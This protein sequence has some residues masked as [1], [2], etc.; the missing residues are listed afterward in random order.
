RQLVQSAI[1]GFDDYPYPLTSATSLQSILDWAN[2]L[3]QGQ[4]KATPLAQAN[5]NYPLTPG[6]K[7]DI[8]NIAYMVQVGDTLAAIA[9]RYADPQ[10]PDNSSAAALILGNQAQ[11]NLIVPGV[12]IA[13]TLDGA[14]RQYTT[15]AGDSFTSIAQAFAITVERLAGETTLYTQA[16]LLSA[17]V[18]L[19]VPNVIVTTAAGDSI[20]SITEALRVPLD[21][22]L[23]AANLVQEGLF[24]VDASLR[25]AIPALVVLPEDGLWQ[26]ILAAGNL[27]QTAGT[28]ARY[29]LHGMRL[30]VA[31][32]L[33]IPSSGFLY[34]AP[35][36]ATAQSA[37]GVYQLTGQQFPLADRAGDYPVTLTRPDDPAYAWFALGSGASLSFDIASQTSLLAKVVA[38]VRQ[39]G[40]RPRI[41]QL[42]A[43]PEMTLAPT[44]YSVANVV[45]WSTSDMAR[46]L[47]LTRS[48]G[49]LQQDASTGPQARPLLFDLSNALLATVEAKQAALALHIASS[50][51]LM[52]YMPVLSASLGISDPATSSTRF[53]DIDACTF[54][55]RIEF[56]IKQLA[57]TADLAPEQPNAND[58]VPPGPGNPGSAARPLA[59]FAY[60]IIGPNPAQT[61][62]LE[63]W[64]TAMASEGE[65]LASGLFLLYADAN[66]GA[67]GLTS[68]ADSEFLSFIVQSNLSTETNPPQAPLTDRLA[69]ADP[70]TGIANTPA[71]FI[72]LLWELSTVNSG[73]SYLFY[74]LLA[75]GTG[76][77][78]EL[79]DESGIAT[80]TLVLT[81]RRDAAQP[82]G[83]RIFN[84]INALLTTAAIDPQASVVQLRGV[85]AATT[86]LTLASDASIAAISN[87]YAID[88]AG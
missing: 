30:P 6:L 88:I 12:L 41:E 38:S 22:F 86:S 26:A 82:K 17:S 32:G 35:H 8:A 66:N 3:Q 51:A 44:R 69:A 87:A 7:L 80:L 28:A 43:E 27:G 42:T 39:N 62:L 33:S 45:P 60:E 71:E 77:P 9:A 65:D 64:L 54:A 50:A 34:G 83:Q 10:V 20:A 46:L 61:V 14:P 67:S 23:T 15:Q 85:N 52:P 81:L 57:Q 73:G 37:Y 76:L 18:V 31:P 70:P 72:K 55:T 40:Y 63:R 59:R 49:T 56:R 53:S 4:L 19:T 58:V 21:S 68:R 79:F 36:W 24:K 29:M 48:P 84:G 75:D 1:D 25:F 13:L 47:E 16:G 74:Q 11:S 2:G 78:P 5:L